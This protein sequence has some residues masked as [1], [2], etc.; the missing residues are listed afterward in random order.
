MPRS[1]WEH[2]RVLPILILQ[3]PKA[4]LAPASAFYCI[5]PV[6]T[7]EVGKVPVVAVPAE[8]KVPSELIANMEME[9]SV[10]LVAYRYL[11]SLDVLSESVP[12]PAGK[13]DPICVKTPVATFRL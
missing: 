3:S 7:R 1:R 2:S 10:L 6:V 11:P 8:V 4:F 12:A 5:V 9:P 13:A